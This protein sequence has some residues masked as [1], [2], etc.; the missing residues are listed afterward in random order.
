MGRHC[1]DAKGR[2]QGFAF[3][4]Y[5]SKGVPRVRMTLAVGSGWQLV[6]SILGQLRPFTPTETCAHLFSSWPAMKKCREGFE[7]FAAPRSRDAKTVHLPVPPLLNPWH[8]PF[9][10]QA[11]PAECGSDGSGND[12]LF[13]WIAYELLSSTPSCSFYASIPISCVRPKKLPLI[14]SSGALPK[15]HKKLL[16]HKSHLSNHYSE[17]L[18]FVAEC[19]RCLMELNSSGGCYYDESVIMGFC[20]DGRVCDKL[21]KRNS[22]KVAKSYA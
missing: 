21:A 5:K 1:A 9:E 8:L 11:Q 7:H 6:V 12:F 19:I 3:R 4:I 2:L 16:M 14:N 17:R 10:F 13:M 15:Q 20:A 18:C 22:M